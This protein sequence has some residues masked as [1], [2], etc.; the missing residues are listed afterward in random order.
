[1][2]VVLVQTDRCTTKQTNSANKCPC[3]QSQTVMQA[4]DRWVASIQAS[5]QPGKQASVQRSAGQWARQQPSRQPGT[6]LAT[7]STPT[8]TA[9]PQHT[10]LSFQFCILQWILLRTAPAEWYLFVP[11]K[12]QI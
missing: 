8:S 6:Y 2:Q 7:R 11:A 5:M 10:T 4:R 12:H 9:Q 1:M 3:E